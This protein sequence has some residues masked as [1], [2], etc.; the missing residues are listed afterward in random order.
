VVT[1][2]G[3]ITYVETPTGRTGIESSGTVIR[4]AGMPVDA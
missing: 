4:A 1:V 3:S 2:S